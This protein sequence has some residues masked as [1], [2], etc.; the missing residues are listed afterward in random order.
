MC[1]HFF[2]TVLALAK[3]FCLFVCFKLYDS[4]SVLPTNL[5]VDTILS[6]QII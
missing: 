3:F 6:V 5:P 2:E 1:S 4:K